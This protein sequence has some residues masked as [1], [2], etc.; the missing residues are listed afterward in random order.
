MVHPGLSR[1]PCGVVSVMIPSAE[2]VV[3]SWVAVPVVTPAVGISPA[4][5]VVGVWVG[6]AESEQA[7]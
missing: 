1:N 5:S 4:P 3:V 6:A 7:Q 2:S